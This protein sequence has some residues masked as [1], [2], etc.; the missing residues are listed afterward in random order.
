MDVTAQ[1]FA[2]DIV[3]SVV[4]YQVTKISLTAPDEYIYI[5]TDKL[6]DKSDSNFQIKS[7]RRIFIALTK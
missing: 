2:Q 7:H 6:S 3:W 5:G 4:S 1:G